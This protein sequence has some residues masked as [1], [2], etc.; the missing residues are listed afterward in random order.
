[1]LAIAVVP[2]EPELPPIA[3]V[4]PVTSGDAPPLD[5]IPPV[6][7][8]PPVSA[9]FPPVVLTDDEPPLEAAPPIATPPPV[10]ALGALVAPPIEEATPPVAIAVALAD[11]PPLLLVPPIVS[12]PPLDVYPAALTNPPVAV[13][14]PPASLHGPAP[15]VVDALLLWQVSDGVPLQLTANRE[16]TAANNRHTFPSLVITMI[17]TPYSEFA[18]RA[19]GTS[20]PVGSRFTA[21]S[22]DAM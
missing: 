9:A 4:P 17:R 7:A 12:E 5:A 21:S 8:T 6:A 3:V 15:A 2:P 11:E 10:P 1:V 20:H 22:V 19:D 14:V 18:P 16:T 13:S